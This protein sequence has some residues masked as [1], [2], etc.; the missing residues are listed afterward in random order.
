MGTGEGVSVPVPVLYKELKEVPLRADVGEGSA[1]LNLIVASPKICL[2]VYDK[3]KFS[4]IP[5][6]LYFLTHLFK[7]YRTGTFWYLLTGTG[8]DN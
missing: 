8:T 7:K 5:K 3:K 6:N 4:Q 2:P 1:T